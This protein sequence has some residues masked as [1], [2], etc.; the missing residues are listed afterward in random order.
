MLKRHHLGLNERYAINLAR[1]VAGADIF[2]KQSDGTT[3]AGQYRQL[4]ISLRQA[5]MERLNGWAAI[6]KRLG[7]EEG[8]IKPTLFFHRRCSRL[9]DC[10]PSLQHDPNR[11]EDVLKTDPDE[12]GIGGDDAADALRYMIATQPQK[13]HQVR[14]R[15]Y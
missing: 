10:L 4:G 13:V 6:H 14:L 12:T 3:I 2:G 9:I 11:P 8:K 15:G 5:N 7:D 1:F